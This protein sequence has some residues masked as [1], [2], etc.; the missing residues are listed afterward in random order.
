MEP[1]VYERLPGR[2]VFG[3]GRLGILAEEVERLGAS[4]V[5]LIS[6][7]SAAEAAAR[8]A[9]ALAGRVVGRIA[10]VRQHVPEED[11]VRACDQALSEAADSLVAVGGGSALGLAKAVAL[12][13]SLPIVAVPTTYSGSE[14]T[15]VYGITAGGRKQTGR[16][17][18]VLPRTVIYDPEL[19]AGLPAEATAATGM[20]ALA[21]CVEA[22]YAR[23]A[24]PVAR[25]LGEEGVRRLVRALPVAVRA[26]CDIDGRSEALYGSSLAGT[27]LASA[28]MA[29]HHKL[30]HVLGGAF[31]MSHGPANAVVLPHVVRFNEP[32]AP[33]AIGRVAQALG[34]EDAAEA[35]F[36]LARSLGAPTSLRQLGMAKEDL[37]AAARMTAESVEWNP[38][39]VT[40][41]DIL[42]ILV[43]AHA[44]RRPAARSPH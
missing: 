43:D 39:P 32:A 24:A 40:E 34:A 13:L 3:P 36:D 6:S 16:N 7:R 25:L 17:L 19:T 21:H 38:R 33:E 15:P 8:A 29:L 14:M 28:G 1:F 9:Q 22:M 23:D 37:D 10:R 27:A 18:K 42:R 44:G 41:E 4:R 35:L 11:A 30:C 2:I 20:N 12:R 5:L 31:G 26:P